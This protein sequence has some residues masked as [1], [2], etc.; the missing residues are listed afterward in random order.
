MYKR[1]DLSVA[2]DLKNMV[3]GRPG[4]EAGTLDVDV[5]GFSVAGKGA[6]IRKQHRRRALLPIENPSKIILLRR[7]IGWPVVHLVRPWIHLRSRQCA[8]IHCEQRPIQGG[9]RNQ[10]KGKGQHE[11]M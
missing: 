4:V 10:Q 11:N 9:G 3:D 8:S 5:E 6:E 7:M 1:Q 2:I